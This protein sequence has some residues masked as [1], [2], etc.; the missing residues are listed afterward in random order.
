M[1]SIIVLL[2]EYGHYKTAKIFWI[3]VE[4]FGLW[5]PPRAKKLW[6]NKDW[7]LF[8]L[9][10][11]PLGWFVKITGESEIF[12]EYYWKKWKK[13]SLAWLWKKLKNHDDV[14]DKKWSKISKQERKYII[15]RWNQQKAGR[16]FYEK[17]IFAKSAVLLAGVVMNFL[18]AVFIFSCFFFMGVKPVGM[19]SFIP[20]DLPSKL[21]P[22]LEQSLESGFITAWEGTLLYPIED[23]IAR[24]SGIIDEDVLL[25]IDNIS[26]ESI[27]ETQTYIQSKASVK[28]ALYLERKTLCTP[29]NAKKIKC[30]IIEYLEIDI[31]PNKDGLIG[32]YLWENLS[33]NQDFEYKYWFFAAG[34]HGFLETYYQAR[35]T[36][37]GLWILLKNIINPKTPKDREDAI[38]Q[39]AGPIGIVNVITQ[40]LQWWFGLLM[41]L[42]AIISINLWVF[43]LL[44]IPALDG[45]RLL[46]LWIRS[47]IDKVLWKSALSGN[48]ENTVHI[49]FFLLLIALSILIAYNDIIK[50]L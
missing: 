17:N 15:A 26:F 35:L 22:T 7:T 11:I 46:L 14:F 37:S 13:L 31:V 10:W 20:T 39:V 19:N 29:D 49:L 1:F 5:I 24:N 44:P 28:I 36:L 40:S 47:A 42:G 9:N 32:T 38:D 23:S 34:K 43:N 33:I 3:H 6:K 50:L 45:W 48:I 41:I 30:P 21:I 25:R 27:L 2:H 16:N 12:L 8:S 18:L 4:E